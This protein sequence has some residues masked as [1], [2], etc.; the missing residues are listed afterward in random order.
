MTFNIISYL[1]SIIRYLRESAL[2]LY[3]FKYLINF[4]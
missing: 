2:F 3:F 4:V 1:N